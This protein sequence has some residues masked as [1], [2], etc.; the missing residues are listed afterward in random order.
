MRP[1]KYDAVVIGSGPAGL[2][3]ALRLA[4]LEKSV[5]LVEREHR[6]GGTG[7]GSAYG[8]WIPQNRLLKEYGIIEDKALCLKWMSKHA[9]PDSFDINKEFYGIPPKDYKLF[10]SYF[11]HAGDAVDFLEKESGVPI[12]FMRNHGDDF[13]SY[14]QNAKMLEQRGLPNNYALQRALPDYRPECEFNQVPLGRYINFRTNFSSVME[15]FLTMFRQ[16]EA[17]VLISGLLEL[18]LPKTLIQ[19]YRGFFGKHDEGAFYYC[20]AGIRMSKVFTKLMHEYKVDIF[21]NASVEDIIIQNGEVKAVMIDQGNRI[22]SLETYNAI[23]TTG[24]FAHNEDLLEKYAPDFPVQ[25]C[26][27]RP[28]CTGNL[29]EKLEDTVQLGHMTDIWQTESVLALAHKDKKANDFIG[30]SNIW[31]MNGDSSIVVDQYGNRCYDESSQYSM[32]S[33]WFRKGDKEIVVHILDQRSVDRFGGLL[34]T[35]SAHLPYFTSSD[36]LRPN[37]IVRGQTIEDMT[38]KLREFLTDY[39]DKISCELSEDFSSNVKENI[40]RFN[41]FAK[42]GVDENF[43]RGS[44][45]MGQGWRARRAKDNNY[46]NKT[47]YPI[48]EVGPYYAM[49]LCLSCFNTKG[50]FQTN[51]HAQVLDKQDNPI[52]GLYAAGNCQ[53]SP[54]NTGYVLSTIGPALTYGFIA[55]NHIVEGLET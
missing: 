16:M 26:A 15:Y 30:S 9:Y 33:K 12:V 1:H 45:L 34:G 17:K 3:T 14:E 48:S 8:I 38:V 11:D 52:K 44:G 41:T 13:D 19:S 29:I 20:G 21:T 35:W 28:S 40:Q 22:K 27:S 24:G 50:G 25:A 54:S 46:P 42:N 10:E 47:M 5:A 32:R 31:H 23:I 18:C 53:A 7:R 49:V 36:L 43:G 2:M 6:L 39:Q 4:K 37:Y 51:A 55:A